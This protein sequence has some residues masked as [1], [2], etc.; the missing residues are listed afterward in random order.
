[1]SLFKKI[2]NYCRNSNE[3][4]S[5]RESERY[6][7]SPQK[8][9]TWRLEAC[10]TCYYIEE[11]NPFDRPECYYCNKKRMYIHEDVV[12]KRKCDKYLEK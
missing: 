11:P 12:N 5:A 3:T 2:A 10:S 4:A 8:E 9:Y 7:N 1:M 6:N